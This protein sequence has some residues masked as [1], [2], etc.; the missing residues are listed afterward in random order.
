M[1]ELSSTELPNC[2]PQSWAVASTSDA[3]RPT[4][5]HHSQT[6]LGMVPLDSRGDL[7]PDHLP[8]ITAA[9]RRESRDK[10]IARVDVSGGRPLRR[11]VLS[12]WQSQRW[13][14]QLSLTA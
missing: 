5:E 1:S 6:G 13:I 14:Q 10:K 8:S 3:A 7:K 2:Y 9:A 12:W 4:P 11:R